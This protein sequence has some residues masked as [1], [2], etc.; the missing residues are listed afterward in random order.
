MRKWRNGALAD[1][2]RNVPVPVRKSI[3]MMRIWNSSVNM[4]RAFNG[5]PSQR[6]VVDIVCGRN[7]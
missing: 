3:W 5:V 6:Y 4:S 7:C 2:I 1:N